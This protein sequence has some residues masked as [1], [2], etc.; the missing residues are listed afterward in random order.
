ML[1]TTS[2]RA[3]DND[4]PT[5]LVRPPW[6]HNLGFNTLRQFHMTAY[7]GEDF[8][9]DDPRGIATAKMRFKD[10]P[11]RGDDDEVTVFGVNAGRRELIYNPSLVE[12]ARFGPNDMP[13]P[14]FDDPVGV[15]TDA[16]AL[17]VVGDR[18]NDRVVFLR[19]GTDSRLRFE[20]AVTLAQTDR[21]LSRPAGVAVSSARVYVADGGNGRIAVLD[22]TGVLVDEIP[23]FDDPFD[24]DVATG[25]PANYDG[26]SVLVVTDRGGRRLS[27]I[28]LAGG[29]TL[30]AD[31]VATTGGDG[32]FGYVALDYYGNTWVTDAGT[33]C[34]YKFD[35]SLALLSRVECDG[36]PGE[37][38]QPRGITINRRLGQVFIAENTGVSYYWVGTDVTGLQAGATVRGAQIVVEVRFVLVE[39]SDVT[40]ELVSGSGDPGVVLAKDVRMPPGTVHRT[41][42]VDAADLPCGVADCTYRVVV[43]ARATYASRKHLEAVRSAPL[44]PPHHQAQ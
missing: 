23:G 28:N 39:R 18:G 20:H 27:R 15:A 38:D 30:S 42:P 34:V 40:V 31:Y 6:K 37:L 25:H 36:E 9:I 32:G 41:Y 22:T 33:G 35:R 14:P 24:V 21:P 16:D 44:R 12:L 43:R 10:A 26:E 7:G 8:E 29:A 5:T 11:G 17:V 2:P 3:E 4:L 1:S 13:A 19:M